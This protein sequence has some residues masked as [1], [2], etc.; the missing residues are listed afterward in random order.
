M[1]R[2]STHIFLMTLLVYGCGEEPGQGR[3]D[4]MPEALS[5]LGD[6]TWATWADRD[7]AR[8][9]NFPVLLYLYSRR[10]EWCRQMST[11]C[12]TDTL[13]VQDI[14]RGTLPISIDVDRRPDLAERFGMGSWPSVLFLTSEGQPITGS[15][16]MDKEDLARLLRRVRVHFDD[17]R[18]REDLRR[19]KV[20]LQA[21]LDRVARKSRM[22]TMVSTGFFEEALDSIRSTAVKGTSP[23]AEGLMLLAQ[24]GRGQGRSELV[25]VASRVVDRLILSPKGEGDG[26]GYHLAPLTPDGTIVDSERNL[27]VNAQL[28]SVLLLLAAGSDSLKYLA[29]A[30]SLG[31]DLLE[32]YL[33]DRDSLLVAGFTGSPNPERAPGRDPTYFASWNALAVT[34]FLDLYEH[35]GDPMFLSVSRS[36]MR[37]ILREMRRSDGL[38][39][40]HPD[41]DPHIP[42]FLEDQA[43]VARALLDLHKA[44]NE[45]EY[46]ELSVELGLLILD[47]FRTND[48]ALQDR[49]PE[50]SNT[51][52]PVVDRLVPSG[53]GTAVQVLSRLHFHF[54]DAGYNLEAGA[55]LGGLVFTDL[56]GY[57]GGLARGILLH[58]QAAGS[59]GAGN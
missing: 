36:L 5:P 32:G 2:W 12:F 1:R 59:I 16:Y 6:V 40:R 50:S 47:L 58:G 11:L 39:R 15:E 35:L 27:P 30:R 46:L 28:I 13:L 21:R 41:Q 37:S 33:D 26:L 24:Y 53:N 48:G 8:Q 44:T 20:F 29:K 55:V 42:L 25:A 52:S 19:E 45:I 9:A 31:H 23:G 49:Y 54:P 3:N 34:G 43:L 22:T 17:D 10:S 56:I 18:R 4:L 7:S 14:R 38:I 57:C 51:I